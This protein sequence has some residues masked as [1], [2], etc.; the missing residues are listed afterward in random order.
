LN[1]AWS[2]RITI[3]SLLLVTAVA[4]ALVAKDDYS[5]LMPVSSSSA[6]DDANDNSSQKKHSKPHQS[7][8]ISDSKVGSL[9]GRVIEETRTPTQKDIPETRLD[10]VLKG[11]F[12]HAEDT[13]ASAL[14]A[15]SNK[16]TDRYFVGD[17]V[18][19]GAEL[20]AVHR[21]EIILRRNGQDERL[22]LP[23]L[24]VDERAD[25]SVGRRTR[26]QRVAPVAQTTATTPNHNTQST[27]SPHQQKLKE[28][29]A[30]LR[31]NRSKTNN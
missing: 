31:D 21:G 28:R 12:T 11:T 29:L 6:N 25:R 18:P 14:I 26:G 30:R 27:N 24:K 15:P 10:L 1:R 2:E 8:L 5:L 3:S 23:M 22:K 19:G 16:K 20:I 9:F 17:Q 7:T 13:K 4:L